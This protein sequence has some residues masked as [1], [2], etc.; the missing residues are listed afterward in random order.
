MSSAK[1][2]YDLTHSELEDVAEQFCLLGESMRLKILRALCRRPLAVGEIVASTA[3]TQSNI[4]RHLSLLASA[5]IITCHKD[6]QFV[7]YG[8]S[9]PL[10]MKL[11]GPVE[12]YLKEE[13]GS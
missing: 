2:T 6:G 4:S 7:Y 10:T 5:G 9:N 12:P 11:K 13:G 3:A 8:I 1:N